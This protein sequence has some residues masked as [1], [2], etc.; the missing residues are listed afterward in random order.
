MRKRLKVINPLI[1]LVN[2]FILFAAHPFF[3]PVDWKRMLRKEIEPPF[4]PHLTGAF[5]VTYFDPNC[6]EA[7]VQAA[8]DIRASPSP[9]DPEDVHTFSVLV[10]IL[11]LSEILFRETRVYR[12][13]IFLFC[14]VLQDFPLWH[15]Q[16]LAPAHHITTQQ[17]ENTLPTPTSPSFS[18]TSNSTPPPQSSPPNTAPPTLLQPSHIHLRGWVSRGHQQH[19]PSP[20][21]LPPL[22]HTPRPRMHCPS[23]LARRPGARFPWILVH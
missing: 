3:A 19:S 10:F 1:C 13:L 4:K 23:L 8:V 22:T 9:S 11:V 18:A 15:Q 6:T 12:K 2:I 16:S 21:S 17:D 5:D 20:L 7:P 14:S